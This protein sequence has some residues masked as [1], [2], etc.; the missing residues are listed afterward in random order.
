MGLTTKQFLA[1]HTREEFEE[2]YFNHYRDETLSHFGISVDVYLAI[3]KKYGIHNTR[4]KRPSRMYDSKHSG[5]YKFYTNGKKQIRV[6][7]GEEVPDGFVHGSFMSEQR[8][9]RRKP[10]SD[11][12]TNKKISITCTQSREEN[13]HKFEQ[14][15]DCT[16]R[17]TLKKQYHNG[18]DRAQWFSNTIP[19][20]KCGG[21]AYIPNSYIPQ[22]ANFKADKMHTQREEITNFAVDNNCTLLNDLISKYGQLKILMDLPKL[23]CGKFK[24]IENKYIADIEEVYN[25]RYLGLSAEEKDL[26]DFI[27]SIYDGEIVE[28]TRS[29]IHNDKTDRGLELDIYLPEKKLAFEFNG[30]YWHSTQANI[31]KRYHLNKSMLCEKEG[32]RLIHIYEDE[33]VT[34]REKIEQLI[35]IALGKVDSKIYARDCEVRTIT[36]KEAQKFSDITHLQGHRDAKITYGLFYK[37]ELVQLMSFS[38]T[39]NARKNGAEWEIIR[40]CPG[41]NNIVVGGV[42][43]LFKHFIRDFN[44]NSVFSYCDFN[45]FNG[46]SY[47]ALGMHFVGYTG[48][49]KY[50]IINSHM[51]PRSPNKY[52]ELKETCDGV[53]WGA[54]SKKYLWVNNE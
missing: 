18:W 10:Q 31:P 8:L 37:D 39:T 42:S 9:S 36:N 21:V 38:Q 12:K 50:W 4:I 30:T 52:K 23:S 24:F 14:E 41:S 19:V 11:K 27:R 54:G 44:P 49:D 35:K 15:N 34:K 43:K 13:K 17:T 7:D 28:N 45:K 25:N 48:P 40:G 33:W 26:V 46:K 20:I 3:A 2:Y 5:S 47:E 1:T 29:I 32:I 53:I 16:L 22:I 6:Y 51:V